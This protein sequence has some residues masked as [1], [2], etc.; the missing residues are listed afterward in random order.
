[1]PLLRSENS[2]EIGPTGSTMRARIRIIDNGPKM[3]PINSAVSG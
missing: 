3:L 2:K 1:M